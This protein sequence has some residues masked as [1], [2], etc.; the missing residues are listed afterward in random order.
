MIYRLQS[1]MSFEAA[2][3]LEDYE[4]DCANLHGHQWNVE[5]EID[6]NV[7]DEQGMVVD[8]KEV[9]KVVKQFDHGYINEMVDFNPT[10]ENLAEYFVN[11]LYKLKTFN[12]VKVS[13][14]E[15]PDNCIIF[16]K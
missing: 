12:R 14:Y 13:I 3:K 16:E 15:T 5:V 10:A 11:E 8:F 2:H 1:K 6:A 7:L 9:K 4:G